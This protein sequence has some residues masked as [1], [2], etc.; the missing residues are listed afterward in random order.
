MSS[1]TVKTKIIGYK[2]TI[3]EYGCVYTNIK[4]EPVIINGAIITNIPLRN[5]M[6]FNK[7]RPKVNDVIE[8]RVG[9]FIP[10]FINTNIGIRDSSHTPIHIPDICPICESALSKNLSG[11]VMKC[12]NP[13]CDRVML[14]QVYNYLKYCCFDQSL[15]FYHIYSLY[16]RKLIR[17][18]DSVYKITIND[19]INIGFSF[20]EAKAIY[21]NIQEHKEIP[22]Q[23][24]YYSLEPEIATNNAIRLASLKSE[25]DKWYVQISKIE[26]N[27][28]IDNDKNNISLD[29]AKVL[30][31]KDLRKNILV[32]KE[33]DTHIN[34]Q[35]V[36]SRLMLSNRRYVID[37]V[38]GFKK[39]FLKIKLSIHGMNLTN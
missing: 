31:N 37:S 33:L 17:N 29:N 5:I 2:H 13:Q 38:G 36:V 18:L 16:S 20:E 10:E 14:R 19:Y 22:L 7:L 15:Q 27:M 9:S 1:E 30:L 24:L 25:M 39:D 8:V 11:T 32:Y 21:S 23:N 28:F 35:P 12:I 3:T 26:S 34:V 6:D 4:I